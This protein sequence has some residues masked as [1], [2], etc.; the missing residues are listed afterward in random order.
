VGS[1][2]GF[3]WVVFDGGRVAPVLGGATGTGGWD[4]PGG[5]DDGPKGWGAGGVIPFKSAVWGT[6]VGTFKSGL[7]VEGGADV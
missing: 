6:E 7:L 4:V 2:G 5:G 1:I 3:C